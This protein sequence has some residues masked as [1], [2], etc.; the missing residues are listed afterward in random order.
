MNKVT[1]KHRE[2]GK[3]VDDG[4][5]THLEAEAFVRRC[6][7]DAHNIEYKIE[8]LVTKKAKKELKEE[9]VD[10]TVHTTG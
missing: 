2:D 7:Y 10:E 6:E 3:W 9:I 5:F 4:E 8:P 1:V